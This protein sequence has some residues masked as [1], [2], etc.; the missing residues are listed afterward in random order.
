[1]CKLYFRPEKDTEENTIYN[2]NIS[3][4]HIQSEHFIG[5]LKGTWQS[6]Q[7]LHVHLD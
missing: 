1:M 6:L 7:G 5:Y 2:Y 3:K 4:V